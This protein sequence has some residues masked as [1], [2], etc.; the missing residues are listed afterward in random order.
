MRTILLLALITTSLLASCQNKI[1]GNT[2]NS[3]NVSYQSKGTDDYKTKKLTFAVS[4]SLNL[5]IKNEN[6]LETYYPIMLIATTGSQLKNC[7]V[8]GF[9]TNPNACNQYKG[10][11]VDCEEKFFKVIYENGTDE[12]LGVSIKGE[13]KEDESEEGALYVSEKGKKI[14]KLDL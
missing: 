11:T 6:G 1:S 14:I 4:D 10:K 5:I 2:H 7:F 13:S 3:L 9:V 12:L 8:M